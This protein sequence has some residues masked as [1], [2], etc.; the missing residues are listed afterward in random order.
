LWARAN[1]PWGAV[2]QFTLPSEPGESASGEY[3]GQNPAA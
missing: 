1:E 2:F 3:A